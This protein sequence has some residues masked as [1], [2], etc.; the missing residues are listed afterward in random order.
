[1]L[2]IPSLKKLSLQNNNF[3]QGLPDVI[4]ALVSLEEL[5][6]KRCQ[7]KAFLG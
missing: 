3:E 4:T 6:A 2:Q 1:M 5:D 7:L